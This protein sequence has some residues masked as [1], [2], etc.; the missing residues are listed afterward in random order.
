MASDII[1]FKKSFKTAL[2]L[3]VSTNKDIVFLYDT[4][5]LEDQVYLDYMANFINLFDRDSIEVFD[6]E[7]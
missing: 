4:N 5:H 1:G 6:Q 3:S 7:F 2:L